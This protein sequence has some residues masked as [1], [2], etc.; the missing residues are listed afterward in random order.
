MNFHHPAGAVQPIF[1]YICAMN[2]SLLFVIVIVLLLLRVFWLHVKANSAKTASFQRLAPKDKMAVLKEC[3]LNNPTQGNIDNLKEFCDSQNLEFDA[4]GYRP[5]IKKQLE[6]AVRRANYVECDALYVE[7][8]K[9]IDKLAPMEFAE[10]SKSR[11]EGDSKGYIAHSLEGISRLYSDNAIL[12]ALEAL[13]PDYAKAEKL[14]TSY[15]ELVRSCNED[16]AD[17]KA[18]EKLRKKRDAWVEDLLSIEY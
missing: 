11:S 16:G 15:Q 3:L 17:E 2:W 13:K 9:F 4:E 7:E 8:C 14:Q 5:F 1:A 18:L 12:D 10:A 6:L